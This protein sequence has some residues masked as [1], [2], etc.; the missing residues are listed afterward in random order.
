P[1]GLA[2]VPAGPGGGQSST[3]ADIIE[4]GRAD[5]DLTREA[6]QSM[7]GQRIQGAVD[8]QSEVNRGRDHGFFHDPKLRE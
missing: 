7:R 2:G 3:A 6:A 5:I 1:R 4:E 8:V